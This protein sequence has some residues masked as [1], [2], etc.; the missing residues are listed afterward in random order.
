MLLVHV[1]ARTQKLSLS[2]SCNTTLP[3]AL[4]TAVV[5][6]LLTP[7]RALSSLYTL[8]AS[9]AVCACGLQVRTLYLEPA[10]RLYAR[11]RG[12]NSTTLVVSHH[13]ADKG[14]WSLVEAIDYCRV[15]LPACST[16]RPSMPTQQ[17]VRPR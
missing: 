15:R 4:L 6:T 14:V 10:L 11:V 3:A 1:R 12:I 5:T 17:S 9:R 13:G 2:L 7:C 8:G 16:P